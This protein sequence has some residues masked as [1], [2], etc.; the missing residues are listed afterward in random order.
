LTALQQACFRGNVEIARILVNH[1]ADVNWSKHKQGY[2]ALMFAAI[3]GNLHLVSFLLS[4]GASVSA[5]N[6]LNRTAS[7]MAA[8]VGNYFVVALISN[9]LDKEKIA[10]FSTRKEANVAKIPAV[11]VNPLHQLVIRLNFS[12][13][14]VS[15]YFVYIFRSYK[16]SSANVCTFNNCFPLLEQWKSVVSV[17]EELLKQF[18]TPHQTHEALALKFHMLACCLKR[19][20]EFYESECSKLEVEPAIQ[21]KEPI[22]CLEPLIKQFL[23]GGDP[24]GLPMGQERFLRKSISTFPRMESTLWQQ[25]VRQVSDVE[26]GLSPTALSILENSI[27]GLSPF[28]RSA[29]GRG[30]DTEPCA[31]CAD[32]GGGGS[33][34]QV[35]RCSR[36]REVAYCS[37]TCQRL[38][39]FTHKKYCPILKEH[40]DAV[41]RHNAEVA[42]KKEKAAPPPV[43]HEVAAE[44][45]A[46][47]EKQ[48]A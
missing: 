8:F 28:S 3:A 36:C 26:P 25:V 46:A 18:F 14:K 44:L 45:Q 5:T 35:K 32:M 43:R 16:I 10:F 33:E 34:V 21:Q 19:A 11:L 4:C 40:H 27:N 22:I 42:A 48:E 37:T 17:L 2:T 29:A 13:V 24:H 39:W 9:Y 41:A 38:H 47:F 6:S 15:R 23:R 1:G 12:P 31:T 7:E 20:G 30:L